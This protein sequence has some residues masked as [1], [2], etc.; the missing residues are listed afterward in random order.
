[1]EFSSQH[2]FGLLSFS[3]AKILLDKLRRWIP[4]REALM[5]K[6]VSRNIALNLHKMIAACLYLKIHHCGQPQT[7]Y[8]KMTTA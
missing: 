2:T 3:S 8:V 1:M 4:A 6:L 5:A 7:F